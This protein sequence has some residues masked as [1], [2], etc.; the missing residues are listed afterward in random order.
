[1]EFTCDHCGGMS[2]GRAYLVLSEESGVVLLRMIVCT[3][4]YLQAK[5]LG[6]Y[7]KEISIYDSSPKARPDFTS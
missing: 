5:K 3:S 4:C 6:L 1:M 7:A 2:S